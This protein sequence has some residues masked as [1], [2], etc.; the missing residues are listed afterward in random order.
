MLVYSLSGLKE[1]L[2]W[3]PTMMGSDHDG[4]YKLVIDIID[5]WVMNSLASLIFIRKGFI[6]LF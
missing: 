4:K 3:D 6:I 5:M 1:F 2:R